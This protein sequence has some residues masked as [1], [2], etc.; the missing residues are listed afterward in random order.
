MYTI[1]D[2]QLTHPNRCTSFLVFFTRFDMKVRE[3]VYLPNTSRRLN[4]RIQLRA[5]ID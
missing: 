2:K 5:Y 1:M 3:H 4:Q